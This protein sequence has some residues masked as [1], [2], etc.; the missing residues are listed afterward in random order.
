MSKNWYEEHHATDE[1]PEFNRWFYEYYGK[2]EDYD[3]ESE[4]DEFWV[5]KSFAL[6]GWNACLS[7]FIKDGM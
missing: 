1:T 5:R 6:R 2:P 4:Q 3:S 7:Q